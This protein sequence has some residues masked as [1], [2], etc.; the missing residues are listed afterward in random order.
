M[1]ATMKLSEVFSAAA[2][3]LVEVGWFGHA[4]AKGTTSPA[5]HECTAMA[6]LSVA[7]GTEG[8]DALGAFLE[9]LGIP[10]LA[11][12]DA[13]WAIADWNDKYKRPTVPLRKLREAAAYYAAEGN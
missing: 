13:F 5:G 3:R 7:R 6:I 4:E 12:G 9:F 11:Y 10:L 1:E 2:D 8:R